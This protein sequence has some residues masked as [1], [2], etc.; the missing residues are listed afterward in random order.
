MRTQPPI[1]EL[2]QI[3]H[4]IFQIYGIFGQSINIKIVFPENMAEIDIPKGSKQRLQD[5]PKIL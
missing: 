2:L 3:K 5:Q 4:I 1:Y